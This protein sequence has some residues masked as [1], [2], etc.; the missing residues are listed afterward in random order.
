MRVI[1]ARSRGK[2]A[3][4]FLGETQLYQFVN[5]CSAVY[6]LLKCKDFSFC[7]QFLSTTQ[8]VES[9]IQVF[10]NLPARS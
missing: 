9:M 3:V 7:S 1:L 8:I 10:H 5:N 2:R 6:K 4:A